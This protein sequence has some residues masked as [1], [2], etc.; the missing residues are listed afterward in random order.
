MRCAVLFISLHIKYPSLNSAHVISIYKSYTF[1][2]LQQ[3][4]GSLVLGP[5]IIQC[6]QFLSEAKV[7]E[8]S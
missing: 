1:I 4:G 3:S 8:D 5:D 7:L 6:M 2:T